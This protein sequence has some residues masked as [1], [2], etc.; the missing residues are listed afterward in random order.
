MPK[1]A[2]LARVDHGDGQTGS[3]EGNRNERLDAP[4]GFQGDEGRGQRHEAGGQLGATNVIV[5]D[6]PAFPVRKGRDI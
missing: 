1:I 6:R 4:G 3:G 2:Y 5:G